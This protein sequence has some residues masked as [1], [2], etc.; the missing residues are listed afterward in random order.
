M[1]EHGHDFGLMVL[2]NQMTDDYAF[3]MNSNIGCRILIFATSNFPDN[4]SG[5]VKEKFLSI[6][7][8]KFAQASND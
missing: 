4:I 8:G 7:E 6:G 2:V 5:A 1:T 3:A